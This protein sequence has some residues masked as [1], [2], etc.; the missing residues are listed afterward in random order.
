MS[1]INL[2][3]DLAKEGTGTFMNL[4][5]NSAQ[6]WKLNV[7]NFLPEHTKQEQKAQ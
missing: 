4:L 1:T 2:A 6:F 5:S 7:A 3:Q